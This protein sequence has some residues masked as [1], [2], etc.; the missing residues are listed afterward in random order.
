MPRH[1][2]IFKVINVLAI[3]TILLVKIS[4]TSHNGGM[5]R[6]TAKAGV[7]IVG[8]SLMLHIIF[9]IIN[10]LAAFV[11][12]LPTDQKKCIIILASLKTL[13]QAIATT[14]LLPPALGM[15]YF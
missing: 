4:V 3:A 2:T 13:G 5:K 10:S 15:S 1:K 7:V 6:L 11:L 9:L 12:R 8:W 14:T